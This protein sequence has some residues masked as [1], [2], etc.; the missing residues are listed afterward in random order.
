M[1]RYDVAATVR[2]SLGLY[3]NRADVDQLVEG[4]QQVREIFG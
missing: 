3:N 2:A 4:L 1:E